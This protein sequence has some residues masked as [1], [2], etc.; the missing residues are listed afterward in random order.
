VL[1]PQTAAAFGHA[2]SSHNS[3]VIHAGLN[4]PLGSLKARLCVQERAGLSALPG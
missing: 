4:H 2:T 3:E 1:L